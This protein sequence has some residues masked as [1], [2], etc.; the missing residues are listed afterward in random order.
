MF[1]CLN[2]F[3]WG[4]YSVL[5]F[6][7]TRM[8][9]TN[10]TQLFASLNADV[11]EEWE[12]GRWP[13]LATVRLKQP[14]FSC[15]EHILCWA[16][17]SPGKPQC[18]MK[19]QVATQSLKSLLPTFFYYIHVK[20]S[21][22]LACVQSCWSLILSLC[23]LS[24]CVCTEG[25]MRKRTGERAAYVQECGGIPGDLKA[26]ALLPLQRLNVGFRWTQTNRL[27]CLLFV[28]FCLFLCCFF[29]FGLGSK[30]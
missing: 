27:L 14:F 29:F 23:C 7:N 26:D 18:P 17:W 19:S 10:R 15:C 8:L 16:T 13:R 30:L 22:A 11:E 1:P 21:V 2:K 25:A 20:L 5:L 12:E 24:S 28:F 4:R 6:F 9:I 3:A